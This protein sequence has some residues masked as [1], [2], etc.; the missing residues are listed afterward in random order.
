LV[1]L[2]LLLLKKRDYELFFF[3]PGLTAV[4]RTAAGKDADMSDFVRLEREH[5]RARRRRQSAAAAAASNFGGGDDDDDCCPH[6][7]PPPV[8][9]EEEE[10]ESDAQIESRLRKL[11]AHLPH[12]KDPMNADYVNYWDIVGLYSFSGE[13]TRGSPR[14]GLLWVGG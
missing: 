8:K 1:L 13:T 4:Y 12:V 10:E 2:L 6:P 9:E 3:L 7:Q 14:A 11:N 5:L